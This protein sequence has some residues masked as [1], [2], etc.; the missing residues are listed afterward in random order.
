MAH[1]SNCGIT[2]QHKILS[3]QVIGKSYDFS[4]ERNRNMNLEST[5]IF[6]NYLQ[7]SSI[8]NNNFLN[9]S[10]FIT[11]Y[12]GSNYDVGNSILLSN[13]ETIIT[14]YRKDINEC[15]TTEQI[16]YCD[17]VSIVFFSILCNFLSIL[18][19]IF[20]YV[21]KC[22]KNHRKYSEINNTTDEEL[23]IDIINEKDN[24]INNSSS[25]DNIIEDENNN[26][27]DKNVNEEEKETLII[28]TK[29]E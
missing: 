25:V 10:C 22:E 8:T 29:I 23:C 6:K 15:F 20:Y 4:I 12:I 13:N 1:L 14:N 3:Q 7:L 2:L 28:K 24:Q 17:G 18:V 16:F 11:V 27:I 5:Y 21:E 9:E 26:I 19:I